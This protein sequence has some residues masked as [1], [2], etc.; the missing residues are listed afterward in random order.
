MQASEF[1]PAELQ[2]SK[3]D[4]SR[5]LEVARHAIKYGLS[6]QIPPQLELEK[7][8][9]SIKHLGASFVTLRESNVMR[10]CVGSVKPHLPLVQDVANHA[11]AAAFQDKRFSPINHIEQPV[12][13]IAVS[14][15]SELVRVEPCSQHQFI[16]LI[17]A[18]KCGVVLNYRGKHS[19]FLPEV[20]R[21]VDNGHEFL[22]RLKR[23]LKLSD[24]FWDEELSFDCYRVQT[25]E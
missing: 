20:W 3:Q 19:T 8:P 1:N 23:N 22:V 18:L 9:A 6:Y 4:W 7:Y 2:L 11:F 21:Q 5:L 15:I 24:E 14:V 12:V 10:G 17:E 25:L 13:H 16:A